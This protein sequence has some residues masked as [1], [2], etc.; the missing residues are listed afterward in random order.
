MVKHELHDVERVYVNDLDSGNNTSF[1]K[2]V[3]SQKQETISTLKSNGNMITDSL[4]KA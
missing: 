2:Y 3:K 4:S 1:W